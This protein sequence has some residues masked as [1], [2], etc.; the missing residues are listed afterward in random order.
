LAPKKINTLNEKSLHAALKRWYRKPG[1]RLEVPL[2][3]YVIDLVRKGLL[4]EIQTANFSTI[5][6]K[7]EALLECHPVRL[8]YPI[9]REKWLI[10][11]PKSKGEKE[12]R[13][14]SPKRGRV[15]GVFAELVYFPR[16]MRHP[17]F[18]LEVLLIQGEEVRHFDARR[19]W[20]RKGWVT[21]ERRL[22]KVVDRTLFETPLDLQ[23]LIPEGLSEP[24]TTL[25]LAQTLAAPRRLAQQMAYCLRKMEALAIQGKRGNAWLYARTSRAR[26]AGL[27]K[28]EHRG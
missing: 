16:L 27:G 13:R 10:K 21:E 19:A 11:L 28:D 7:L 26:A 24:F 23:A 1:D 18:S 15:E 5:R 12:T 6:H 22:L 14:K 8:V 17:N 3:G 20:R 4:V 25:E 2:D 9:E